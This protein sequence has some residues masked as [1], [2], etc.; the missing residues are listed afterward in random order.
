MIFIAVYY[1]ENKE[2]DIANLS[3]PS[4]CTINTSK[5]GGKYGIPNLGIH[6]IYLQNLVS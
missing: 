1:Q 2:K 5:E 3:K 4:K 6:K